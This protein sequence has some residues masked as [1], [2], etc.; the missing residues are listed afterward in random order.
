MLAKQ[1]QQSPLY[2]LL[3]VVSRARKTLWVSTTA[4]MYMNLPGTLALY[5]W[6]A[7]ILIPRLKQANK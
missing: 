4:T 2:T 3:A 7:T 1:S 6:V 5:R